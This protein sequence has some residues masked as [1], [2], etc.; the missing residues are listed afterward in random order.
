MTRHNIL[1]VC[2]GNICR[3][4]MAEGVFRTIVT[5]AGLGDRFHIDS[6]GTGSWHLGDPPDRR[7]QRAAK[8]RGIDISDQRARCIEQADFDR[9]DLIL[10]MDQGNLGDLMHAAPEARTDRVRLFLEFAPEL[11]RREVPDPYYGGTDGFEH[12]LDLV[13]TAGRGLLEA[14]QKPR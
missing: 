3:S 2:L 8:A 14:L 4:P 12:V 10:A 7:A 11:G 9:F 13:E 5:E 1:F 6:A